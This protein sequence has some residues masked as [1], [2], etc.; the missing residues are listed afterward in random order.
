MRGGTTLSP[1][2]DLALSTLLLA[3]DVEGSLPFQALILPSQSTV[4]NNSY[5]SG[6]S[7]STVHASVGPSKKSFLTI[8]SPLPIAAAH[9][10]FAPF[11]LILSTNAPPGIHSASPIRTALL[12]TQQLT[13]SQG[14]FFLLFKNILRSR[15]LVSE[16]G[17][18]TK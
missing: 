10:F 18:S 15:Y 1:P 16:L 13:T 14:G 6:K 5:D 9:P 7:L 4:S 11:P 12:C 2:A 8:H 17:L 3:T